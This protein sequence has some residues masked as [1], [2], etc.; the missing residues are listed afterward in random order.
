MLSV[1]AVLALAAPAQAKATEHAV[2]GGGCFWAMQ[3]E[4]ELLKG[5][6]SAIPGY[7]GG[8]V[9]NPSYQQVCSH[10][11]GHAEVIDVSY[12]PAVISYKDLVRVFMRAHDPTTRDRQGNDVGDNYRSIILT[13]SEAQASTAKA[14][15]AELGRAHAYPDPIVTE[16]KPLSKFYQAES[17]HL[18][19]YDQHPNEPYC[20][21]VVAHEIAS[22]KAKFKDRLK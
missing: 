12:D 10:T 19:Y 3:S 14:V 16:V 18:H 9:A 2:F 11:T 21:N 15:I 13:A 6:K 1:V 22:F 20:A 5:V 7:A 17:Y 4:F 8:H